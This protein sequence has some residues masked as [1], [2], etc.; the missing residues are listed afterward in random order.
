M[1]NIQKL[2][3]NYFTCF[4]TKS[5]NS[6]VCF[7]LRACLSADWPRRVLGGHVWL[8]A[9]VP[10]GRARSRPMCF[11]FN[12]PIIFISYTHSPFK[13]LKSPV[14]LFVNTTA[15]PTSS[16]DGFPPLALPLVL[17]SVPQ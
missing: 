2:L 8:A 7:T 14:R 15:V 4:Q 1:I 12:L 13:E 11:L 3:T 6:G 5:S 10:H 9:T 16:G 17:S